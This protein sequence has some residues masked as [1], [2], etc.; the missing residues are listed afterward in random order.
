MELKLKNSVNLYPHPP[1]GNEN[2]AWFIPIADVEIPPEE[3]SSHA[4]GR[5]PKPKAK[6][7][8]PS[9]V[10]LNAQRRAGETEITNPLIENAKK[11][12][13]KAHTE[14]QNV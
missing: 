2:Q 11:R 3:T 14:V 6:T 13:L 12:A 1:E 9:P 10:I 8:K 5:A 7:E 4:K